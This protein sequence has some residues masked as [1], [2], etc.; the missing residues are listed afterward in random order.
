[1]VGNNRGHPN[2]SSA[3]EIRLLPRT[4]KVIPNRR[5][6][7]GVLERHDGVVGLTTTGLNAGRTSAAQREK[8]RANDERHR[9]T[10]HSCFISEFTLDGVAT[11]LE[12]MTKARP[13]SG[14][15]KI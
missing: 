12:A 7:V 2:N 8:K 5:L 1:L 14:P 9:T 6:Q 13:A 4:L 3:G 10:V 15:D 11:F